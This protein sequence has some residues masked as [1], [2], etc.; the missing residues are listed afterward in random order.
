MTPERAA[1]VIRSHPAIE[2]MHWVLDV[3]FKEDQSR[4]RRGHG[5]INMA[6]IRRLAFSLLKQRRGKKSLK[7]ARKMAGWNPAFLAQ[8]L[9]P[10][11]C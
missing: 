11:S 8:I 9:K 1:L 5:A 3:I 10:Q 6:L 2:G 4:L 7:T